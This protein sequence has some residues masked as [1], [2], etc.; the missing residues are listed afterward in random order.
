[1]NPVRDDPIS[2]V[3]DERL[4]V[5]D[6]A[7][8]KIKICGITNAADAFAAIESGADIL[9][10]NFYRRS[11][12][13]IDMSEASQWLK[14]LPGEVV[15]IAVLVGPTV[16][17]AV[18]VAELP[19]IDAL[20]LHGDESPDFCRMLSERSYK[21]IK[22]IGVRDETS[23]RDLPFYFT[24]TILLDSRSST[25][26]GSGQ[27]FPWESGAEF[28]GDHPDLQ[29]VIAGG[30]TPGNV[31]AAIQKVR[32]F[33]VDVT[34]GVESSPGRKDIALLKRFV[35]AVRGTPQKVE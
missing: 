14:Q 29:V 1:M 6:P 34:T 30:L 22:A 2:A 28:I 11:S 33:A 25:F 3:F 26:G 18:E 16:A 32:P 20:Q 35:G 12:R 10:F 24:R 9:G 4:N 21:F 5:A 15:K 8:V 7:R 19:F 27:M 13:Y 17:E 23:L 31:T